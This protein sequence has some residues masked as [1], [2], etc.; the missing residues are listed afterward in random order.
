M[1]PA[2]LTWPHGT[3]SRRPSRIAQPQPEPGVLV[4]RTPSGRTYVAAPT[5]YP[6]RPPTL[7]CIAPKEV[8]V[9]PQPGDERAARRASRSRMRASHADREQVV[10]TLKE[11]FVQGRLTKDEFDSR[12]AN[13]LAARTYAD[14]APLSTDLPAAPRRCPAARQTRPGTQTC[15]RTPSEPRGQ[16]RRSRNRSDNRAHRGP[17]GGRVAQPSRQPGARRP[18][19]RRHLYLVRSRAPGRIGDARVAVPQAVRPQPAGRWPATAMLRVAQ[20]GV[21]SLVS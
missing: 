15:P 8:L 5:V 14:L 11:A 2:G 6:A 16:E 3:F 18:G 13:A 21:T 17:M 7:V 20:L 9:I 10:D 4:W 1:G 19:I 12:V